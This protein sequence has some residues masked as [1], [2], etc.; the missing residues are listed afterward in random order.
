MPAACLGAS[1]AA[2]HW[3]QRVTQA[4]THACLCLDVWQRNKTEESMENVRKKG[5]TFICSSLMGIFFLS[6]SQCCNYR[7]IC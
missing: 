3:T 4:Y 7:T 1:L 2:R 5:K 6:V